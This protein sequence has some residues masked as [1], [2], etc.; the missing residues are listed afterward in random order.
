MQSNP[1]TAVS[2]SPRVYFLVPATGRAS[3]FSIPSVRSFAGKEHDGSAEALQTLAEGPGASS[4]QTEAQAT[5]RGSLE[6]GVSVLLE[7]GLLKVQ[8]ESSIQLLFSTF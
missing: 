8:T 5:A 4:S 2:F 7:E 3:P 6:L 1:Y